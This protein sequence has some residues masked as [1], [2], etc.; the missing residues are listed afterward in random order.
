M[1]RIADLGEACDAGIK[2]LK[3]LMEGSPDAEGALKD[4]AGLQSVQLSA[5]SEAIHAYFDYSGKG[6]TD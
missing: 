6:P 2:T 4:N 5:A 1:S 3:K